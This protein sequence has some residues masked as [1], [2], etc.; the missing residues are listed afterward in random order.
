MLTVPAWFTPYTNGSTF[1]V[2]AP[3][4]SSDLMSPWGAFLAAASLPPNSTSPDVPGTS[5][6]SMACQQLIYHDINNKQRR[7]TNYNYCDYNVKYDA[8]QGGYIHAGTPE[9]TLIDTMSAAAWI[10]LPT[11]HGVVFLGQLASTLPGFRY[12][13]GGTT[14]HV[15]YGVPTCVHGQ[16]G[17]P[18]SQGTGPAAGTMVPYL[19]VYDPADLVQSAQGRV[20][21][22]SF[23][24]SSVIPVSSISTMSGPANAWCMFGG[25]YF[26]AL[27]STLFVSQ[28]AIDWTASPY[29]SQPVVH[30]FKIRG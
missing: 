25:A 21:P 22:W 24:P 10:D 6:V 11:K 12:P 28:I 18:V 29:E 17:A 23:D 5:H 9:F 3:I 1:G 20:K 13:D 26:D 8:S 16:S 2:G 15:W 27:T 14:C 4:T 7:D 30:V 19:W